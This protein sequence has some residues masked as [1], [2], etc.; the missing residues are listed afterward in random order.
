MGF[1]AL[2]INRIHFDT[3]VLYVCVCVC[4]GMCVCD[5]CVWRVIC[6]CDVC[7]WCVCVCVCVMGVCVN[8]CIN[9]LS[10]A[11]VY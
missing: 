1:D 2:V 9:G 4:D 5:V 10:D 8:V 6:V 3:K 7:M 11:L